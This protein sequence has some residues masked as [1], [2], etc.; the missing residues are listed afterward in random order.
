MRDF[1]SAIVHTESK[2]R[3]RLLGQSSGLSPEVGDLVSLV[4]DIG[5]GV[6]ESWAFEWLLYFPNPSIQAQ[7]GPVIIQGDGERDNEIAR[8][9]FSPD[10]GE[11]LEEIRESIINDQAED[12]TVFFNVS[13]GGR[14]KSSKAR[15]AYYIFQ[16]FV[17][18][19]ASSDQ[20]AVFSLSLRECSILRS[21]PMGEMYEGLLFIAGPSL[22]EEDEEDLDRDVPAIYDEFESDVEQQKR[23]PITTSLENGQGPPRGNGSSKGPPNDSNPSG[24]N[25]SQAM[26]NGG[27]RGGMDVTDDLGDIDWNSPLLRY[28]SRERSADVNV[29]KNEGVLLIQHLL[30]DFVDFARGVTNLGFQRDQLRT[31]GI[32][33]STKDYVVNELR[34]MGFS[35]EAPR[36]YPF[37]DT[38]S[39][40]LREMEND[41]DS[42]IIV[43]DGGYVTPQL[44][45]DMSDVKSNVIGTVEQT[46]NG[47]DRTKTAIQTSDSN[48]LSVVNVAECESKVEIESRLVGEAVVHNIRR[49]LIKLGRGIRGTRA[50]VVGYGTIGQ[51]VAEELD[52]IGAVGPRI[53]DENEKKLAMAKSEGFETFSN[54][55]VACEDAGLVIG[56]TGKLP[57]GRGELLSLKQGTVVVNAS[58]KRREIDYSELDS[59][60]QQGDLIEGVAREWVFSSR[61]KKIFALADGFPVNFF[62]AESIPDEEIQFVPTFL[63]EG[64]VQLLQG[65][66]DQGIHEFGDLTMDKNGEEKFVEQEIMDAHTDL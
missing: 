5:E 42:I 15:S 8:H 19:S 49:L 63:L 40:Q 26:V 22:G 57:I 34:R 37:Q 27:T 52:R 62:D 58:S 28:W 20:A 7:S 35:V 55:S 2:H 9:D 29:D 65:S 12:E 39:Q 16:E 18:L 17:D 59:L 4:T 13:Q 14:R 41:F 60:A 1:K 30:G 23:Q 47:M 38:V 31:I 33:Y 45:D 64:L 36:S 46:T 3:K 61:E 10:L 43:E 51:K 25:E 44:F 21:E 66:L 53:Y 50:L 54:L 32:P 11:A 24:E 56:C 6:R 48:P